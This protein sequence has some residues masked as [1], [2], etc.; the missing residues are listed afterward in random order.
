MV[1]VVV[2][3]WAGWGSFGIFSLMRQ[4]VLEIFFF[5]LHSRMCVLPDGH[6]AGRTHWSGIHHKRQSTYIHDSVIKWFVHA[7]SFMEPSYQST[8]LSIFN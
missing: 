7:L 3:G 6:L 8:G 5:F 1:V 4:S 2:G